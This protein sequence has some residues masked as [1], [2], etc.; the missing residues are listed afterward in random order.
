[1][2]LLHKV[3]IGNCCSGPDKTDA[4]SQQMI[5]CFLDLVNDPESGCV[6]LEAS[7]MTFVTNVKMR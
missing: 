6:I 1:V 7:R 3:V 4:K 2:K 5:E